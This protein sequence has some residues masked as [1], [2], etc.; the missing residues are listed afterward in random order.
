MTLQ[1][2][3]ATVMRRFEIAL[4]VEKILATCSFFP[5]KHYFGKIH[6]PLRFVQNQEAD[7]LALTII[8]GKKRQKAL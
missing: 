8:S 1:I 3:I 6:M 7:Q 4:D 5:G 2:L